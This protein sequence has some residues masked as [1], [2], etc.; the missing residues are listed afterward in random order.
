MDAR[1]RAKEK[2]K[3]R[4]KELV[5]CT[6]IDCGTEYEISRGRF[7]RIKDGNYRCPICMKKWHDAE[8][9]KTWA[10]KTAEEMNA[11][12]NKKTEAWNNKSDEERA[13]QV[14]GMH[15]QYRNLSEEEKRIR[16]DKLQ[17]GSQN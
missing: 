8:V 9:T 13:K 3:L 10:N 12:N 5:K 1:E 15:Q 11:I 7:R 4:D 14:A 17:Q 16:N 2:A 6:C